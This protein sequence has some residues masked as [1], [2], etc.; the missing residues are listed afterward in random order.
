MASHSERVRGLRKNGRYECSPS[1]QELPAG[2]SKGRD[3]VS[4]FRCFLHAA[5]PLY[6]YSVY[7]VIICLGPLLFPILL[8]ADYN[9]FRLM[10]AGLMDVYPMATV[11]LNGFMARFGE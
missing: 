7:F 6:F 10:S 4:T 11:S 8:G 2:P 1:Q 9:L 3:W 5:C